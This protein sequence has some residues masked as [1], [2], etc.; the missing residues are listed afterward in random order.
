M[1]IL[2]SNMNYSP[3][4]HYECRWFYSLF[5]FQV[6]LLYY[7]VFAHCPSTF[8]P[9]MQQILGTTK[10]LIQSTWPT[11]QKRKGKSPCF[12]L[13]FSTY[14]I[15]P[16]VCW[17]RSNELRII[18]L[19]VALVQKRGHFFNTSLSVSVSVTE[20]VSDF[21][22]YLFYIPLLD[23]MALFSRKHSELNRPI[24]FEVCGFWGGVLFGLDV[25]GYLFQRLVMNNI[26]NNGKKR[27]Q[28]ILI[29]QSD[30]NLTF[31]S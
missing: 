7:F 19:R 9:R 31:L 16:I 10:L 11:L 12:F 25:A 15:V 8:T 30:V 21:N 14:G 1:I 28:N 4:T 27:N 26:N 5:L 20:V 23:R 18:C 3:I 13:S 2:E 29:K 6:V 24:F 22:N 17:G